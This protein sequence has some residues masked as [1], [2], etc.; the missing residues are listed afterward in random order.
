ML[1]D[2]VVYSDSW[3]KTLFECLAAAQLTVNLVK[4]EFS[5]ATVTYI[6]HVVVGQAPVRPVQAKVLATEQFPSLTT[7]N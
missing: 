2:A 7:K 4:C 6:G 5:H 3:D 1:D